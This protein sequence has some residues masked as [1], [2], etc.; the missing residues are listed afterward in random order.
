MKT[1]IKNNALKVYYFSYCALGRV[2][3]V[4][5]P[6]GS[7]EVTLDQLEELRKIETFKTLEDD[8]I[9][10]I[11]SVE[12]AMPIEAVKVEKPKSKSKKA[13]KK[14]SPNLDLESL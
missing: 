8:Q 3:T 14:V 4:A 1:T 13:T 2:V 9:M 7:T 10:D 11:Y 12:K 5:L 6:P